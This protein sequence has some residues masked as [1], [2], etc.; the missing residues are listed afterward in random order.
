VDTIRVLL[1]LRSELLTDVVASQIK[2]EPDL[3]VVGVATDPVDILVEVAR[4]QADVVISEWP[5]PEIM[6]GI[7]THLLTEYPGLV[8]LGVSRDSDQAIAARQTITK[9][10]VESAGINELLSEIR[11]AKAEVELVEC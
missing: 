2:G 4:T 9:T 8:F 10:T 7:C 6:P 3:Q 11:H 1:A 5:D